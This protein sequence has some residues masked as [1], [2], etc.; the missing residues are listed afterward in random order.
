MVTARRAALTQAHAYAPR[1]K[2]IEPCSVRTANDPASPNSVIT[3]T[4]QSDQAGR[5]VRSDPH[6]AQMRLPKC[7]L[8]FCLPNTPSTCR[9]ARGCGAPSHDGKDGSARSDLIIAVVRLVAI[10][11]LAE[12]LS[13]QKNQVPVNGV[14]YARRGQ[15]CAR[16]PLRSAFVLHDVNHVSATWLTTG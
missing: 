15:N 9:R 16:N 12:S 13:K 11:S 3:R 6:K 7:R 14:A 4:A 10:S 8:T 2:V 1:P 5:G